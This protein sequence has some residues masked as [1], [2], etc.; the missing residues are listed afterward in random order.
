WIGIGAY[1]QTVTGFAMGLIIMGA[2]TL[3]DL[4]PV[5]FT[6]VV[7]TMT[8]MFNIL[9]A[10]AREHHHIHWRT[11]LLASLG[12]AP[13]LILGVWLLNYLSVEST[14]TLKALLGGFI[15]VGATLLVLKP[16]PRNRLLL[17]WRD[18]VAGAL[19][20]FFGGLFSTAGPPLV[21][22]LY[23]QPFSIDVVRTSLLAIFGFTTV[24]RNGYVAA[25]G[26]FTL[27]M[28]HTSLL[29]IPVVYLA[30]VLGQRF[31]PPLAETGMRRLAFALLAVL[32]ILLLL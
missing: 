15:L 24:L 31:P 3:F 11:V 19:G 23:R 13:A 30:T 5:A 32:G 22:H 29:A 16:H 20:G 7:I 14:Q 10:L 26:D 2:A 17:G 12:M 4:V 28:L 25:S 18:V 8:S 27:E 9:L 21:Y 1:V 6:A